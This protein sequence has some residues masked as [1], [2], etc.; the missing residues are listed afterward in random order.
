VQPD[1]DN[2]NLLILS[3]VPARSLFAITVQ[4][5]TATVN[6]LTLS[7]VPTTNRHQGQAFQNW[8]VCL[9]T[10]LLWPLCNVIQRLS[11][12]DTNREH[13]NQQGMVKLLEHVF[14]VLAQVF[15]G[16]VGKCK[17]SGSDT[18]Q[19]EDTAIHSVRS[20]L[21]LHSLVAAALQNVVAA[22]VQPGSDTLS[23]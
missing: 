20:N 23:R 14:K 5:E 2:L 15:S 12:P 11:S 13:C 18:A 6:C 1:P 7:E 8:L 3:Q 19:A 10:V 17:V 4:F 9:A 16:A 21:L 22:A